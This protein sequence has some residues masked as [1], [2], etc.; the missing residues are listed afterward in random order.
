[1]KKLLLITAGVILLS[2]C[3]RGCQ[4]FEKNFQTTNRDYEITMYSGG[5]PVYKDKFNGIVNDTD[6][7]DG[8]YYTKGD[9]LIEVSGDYILKSVD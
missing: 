6:G 8:C 1:M 4:R 2:S 7:S 3:Q 5:E 9:T